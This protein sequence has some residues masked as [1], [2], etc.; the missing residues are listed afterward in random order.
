MALL[1]AHPN[2]REMVA[3]IVAAKAGGMKIDIQVIRNPNLPNNSQSPPLYA[4][5]STPNGCENIPIV[6]AVSILDE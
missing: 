1:R 4:A 6:G 3:T 2:Y 5:T